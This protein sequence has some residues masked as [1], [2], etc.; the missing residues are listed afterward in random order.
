LLLFEARWLKEKNFQDIVKDAWEASA[1]QVDN[2]LTGRLALVHDNLH[3]WDR[4]ILKKPQ[5]KI[6]SI[7]REVENITRSEIT[8][9]NIAH[10]RD[11]VAK[12]EKLLE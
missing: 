11:L 1:H 3:R 12:L 7:R 6:N 4:M 9:E 8:E 2:G 5:R 10:E